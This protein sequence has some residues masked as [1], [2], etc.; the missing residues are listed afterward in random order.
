MVNLTTK[1]AQPEINPEDMGWSPQNAHRYLQKQINEICKRIKVEQKTNESFRDDFSSILHFKFF[2][3][4][5]L[6]N[7]ETKMK[8]YEQDLQI[9]R[10]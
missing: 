1:T 2:T 10:D 5:N 9:V 6:M 4:E 3:E 8:K 7:V